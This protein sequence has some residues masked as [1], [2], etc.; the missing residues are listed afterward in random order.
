LI[1]LPPQR[2]AAGLSALILVVLLLPLVLVAIM[3]VNPVPNLVF[4]PKGISFHWYANLFHT[5]QFAIGLGYSL[6]LGAASTGIG[7]VSG[8]AASYAIV[9]HRFPGRNLLNAILMSPLIIP[10]IVIGIGL[11]VLFSASVGG[12]GTGGLV[13][14]H[15]LIVLPYVVRVISANLMTTDANL[16]DAALLL[17]ASRMHAFFAITL[18]TIGKGIATAVLFCLTIST[19]NFTA[20]VFLI[21]TT[22]T[23]PIAVYS[24][25][26]TEGDPTIAALSTI[27]TAL[28]VLIVWVIDKTLGVRRFA[29]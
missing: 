4:P 19:H 1:A 24:Y 3:S 17:G 16:E 11:L 22:P 23:L 18:P 29:Q 2:V 6:L 28:A 25:I 20:T 12:V 7:L 21:T 8:T 27:V 13:A 14:L 9:R 5:D 15:S 26:A 10:E